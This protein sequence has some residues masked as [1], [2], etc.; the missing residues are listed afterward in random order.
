VNWLLDEHR[1]RS[2]ETVHQVELDLVDELHVAQ[3]R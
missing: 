2:P 1:E 3:R